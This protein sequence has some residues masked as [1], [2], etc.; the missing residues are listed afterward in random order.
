MVHALTITAPFGA[1]WTNK[2]WFTQIIA[3]KSNIKRGCFHTFVAFESHL[4]QL[5][6]LF[7]FPF[8]ACSL[9]N[10]GMDF[11]CVLM[12]HQ[13]NSTYTTWNG[14]W[15]THSRDASIKESKVWFRFRDF[16]WRVSQRGPVNAYEF[17]CVIIKLNIRMIY[18]ICGALLW[19]G[20]R[21]AMNSR[22]TNKCLYYINFDSITNC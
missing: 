9:S 18:R 10:Y 20:K 16:I 19:K 13:L 12:F 22:Y 2:I 17:L 1:M 14:K 6:A 7:C 4:M 11:V 21:Y 5:L 3:K 8:Y 15:W